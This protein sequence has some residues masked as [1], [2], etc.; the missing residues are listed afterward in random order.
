MVESA[1]AIL[2]EQ[3][4]EQKTLKLT[5][6]YSS[7]PAHS[8]RQL[9]VAALRFTLNSGTLSPTQSKFETKSSD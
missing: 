2:R 1:I 5:A 6:L 8:N 7:L 3:L 9:T 4:R